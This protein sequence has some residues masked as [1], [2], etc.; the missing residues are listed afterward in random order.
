MKMTN[1]ILLASLISLSAVAQTKSPAPPT[2]KEVDITKD[3]KIQL[4]EYRE[5]VMQASNAQ[6]QHKS[7]DQQRLDESIKELNQLAE[8]IQKAHKCT[9]MIDSNYKCKT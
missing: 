4:L 2:L 5:K 6:M 7:D 8:T 1:L 9:T 3:E